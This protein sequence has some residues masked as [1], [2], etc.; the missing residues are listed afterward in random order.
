MELIELVRNN[1]GKP[2]EDLEFLLTCLKEVMMESGEEELAT[3]IPWI[4]PAKNN[5]PAS[6]AEKQ[7]QLYSICFQLFE[8]CVYFISTC[9]FDFFKKILNFRKNISSN[10]VM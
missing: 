4:N 2:Y 8:E 3:E 9:S 7:L 10:V 5:P 1:L 6:F